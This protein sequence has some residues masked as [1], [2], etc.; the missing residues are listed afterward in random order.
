VKLTGGT[1]RHRI[2]ALV[3]PSAEQFMERTNFDLLFLGTNAV[4]PERIG[5]DP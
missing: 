3:D 2:R 1:L 4:D 5:G